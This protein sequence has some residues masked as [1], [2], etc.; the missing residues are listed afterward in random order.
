MNKIEINVLTNFYLS[1]LELPNLVL[2][3]L[4]WKHE[5]FWFNVLLKI[6]IMTQ[7]GKRGA[8]RGRVKG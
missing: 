3:R 7:V 8:G 4:F 1:T 2:K 6:I 5:K